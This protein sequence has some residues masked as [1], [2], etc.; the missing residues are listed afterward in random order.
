MVAQRAVMHGRPGHCWPCVNL[1]DCDYRTCIASTPRL[2]LLCIL[3]SSSNDLHA[4]LPL[5]LGHHFTREERVKFRETRRVGLSQ[6]PPSRWQP[7]PSPLPPPAPQGSSLL[8]STTHIDIA[9]FTQHILFRQ[10]YTP[11]LDECINLSPFYFPFSSP[12]SG[13]ASPLLAPE[14]RVLQRVTTASDPPP[15]TNK[16]TVMAFVFKRN[17]RKERVAFDKITSRWVAVVVVVADGGQGLG[18]RRVV[19]EGQSKTRGGQGD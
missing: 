8:L 15:S 7:P 3:T 5:A 18:E 17:G 11:L 16:Q 14:R 1:S 9:H 2:V 12:S 6:Q 4:S 10:Q 19:A 13:S